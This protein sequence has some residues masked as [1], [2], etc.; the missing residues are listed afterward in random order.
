MT[1]TIAD[2]KN[3]KIKDR[4]YKLTDAHGLFLQVSPV[5]TKSWRFRYRHG[6]KERLLSFG[7]YPQIGLA[8]ARV[9]R[10]DAR[11]LLLEGK[12][13]V[14]E[15]RRER[16]RKLDAAEATFRRVADEW[17]SDHAPLWSLSN[18]TRVRNR[19]ERDLYPVFGSTPIGMIESSDIL[20]ALRSIEARGSIETAKRVRGYIRSVFKKAKGEQLVTVAMIMEIDELRD[21]LKPARRGRRQPA[22]TTIPELLDLQ[23]CVDRAKSSIAIKLASRLLGLTA[24]RIG[25]LRAAPWTE[26]EGIDWAKPDACCEKAIWRI[27]AG[28][29]KLEL[30]DKFNPG[31]GHDVP[32]SSQAVDV[33]RAIRVVTGTSPYLF[34][35]AKS[36]R[37]P[38]T[39]A[40]LSC[41]YKRM[42][43]GRFKNRMVPHGW[44]SA[45]STIMNER[46][47]ELER[48]GDRV[49]IDMI[50]AHVPEGVSASEWAYNRARYLKPRRA[51]LQIWADLITD[52]LREPMT[53]LAKGSTG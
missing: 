11:D 7:R 23:Q 31:F 35:N 25:V 8:A 50:L 24:V 52:N 26:F 33:L 18:A 42:A 51:L 53:L 12:D 4:T 5:G 39:D 41:M 43:N 38:M 37:E 6:G 1:L 46:A 47:A 45:F 16:Q 32:L 40:A 44:R 14:L 2:I 10:D 20:R 27:P 48:D 49:M 30:E 34:P 21:A 13:P 17:L 22:L 9:A 36:W 3:A 29:M 28:R 19:F 15:K